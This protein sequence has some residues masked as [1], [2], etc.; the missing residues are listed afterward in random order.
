MLK[1]KEEI[2]I[3]N[4]FLIELL[5]LLDQQKSKTQINA[6]IKEME[7]SIR[8]LKLVGI[9]AKGDTK[10]EVNQTIRQMEGNLRQIKIQAK[11]DSRQLNRE[12]NSALRNVSARDIQLNVSSSERLGIQV[13]RAV[14][15]AREFVSRNPISVNIDLKKE[16]LLNQLT[17]FTNKHTKINESSY[18]LGE[19]ER[20]RNVIGSITNRDELRNAT[21]Q[22]QVFT[23]GVRATGYAAVSTTDRI[24]GMLGNVV[25]IS[26][27]FG[28]AFMAVNKFR[29]SINT[30]KTND[31]ILVEISKTSEMTKQQLRELGDEAFAVASKF[32]Q[33]S[34]NYLLAVQ[35]MA[36]SGYE[37]MSKELGQLS[38]L[39]Q[40]AG[41]MT[42]EM[43]NNYLLAT[44]AAYKYGGSVDK[45]TAALDGA[46]YISNKNSASLTDIADGIRVSASFAANAGV[47]IDEL[48]AAEA[49]MVAATKRSG[50]EMGR[51]FRS[52]ILNLQ[53]ISGEF[54]GEVI[55]E[56]QLK[57]VEDRC[58]SLGVELEYIKDGVATLRNPMEILKDLAEVYNSLPDNSAEK[59]GL[60]SDIGGKY[61]ANALSALLSRWDLYEKMVGEFSQ[62]TGSALEE[63]NKTADSWEGRLNSLSNSF[64]SFVA[65]ITNKDVIKGG[66][67]FLDN[68]IQS[69]EKLSDTI[70]AIPVILTTF[71]AGMTALNKNYGITQLY[72]K[73][74]HKMDIQGNIMGIDITAFKT[75]QK[76]FREAANAILTWNNQLL[77][78]TADIDAFG[79][80]VVQNNE[81]LKA[82][83]QTTSV[84]APASLA[85]YRSYLA[86]C[87]VS[88]DALR[89]KTVLLNSAL[90][91]GLSL[92]IQAVATAVSSFIRVSG[93]VAQKADEV[94]N[95]FTSAKTDIEGYKSKVEEL[96][97]VLNDSGSSISDVTEARKSLMSIQDELIEKY[98]AEKGA[99][100]LITEGINGQADAFDK[101]AE[102]QWQEAKN[103]FNGGG[104]ANDAAN[105]INGYSDNIDRMLDEYGNYKVKLDLSVATTGLSPEEAEGL[106]GLF[107]SNG[108]EVT[109]GMKGTYSNN[110]FVELSGNAT[111]MHEK[112]LELQE[113][114][115]DENPL[116]TDNFRNY[117]TGLANSAKEVS[118][119]YKDMYDNYTLYKGIAGNEGY[120]S[121]FGNIKD[122]YQKYQGAKVS[123]N[124]QEIAE[125]AESYAKIVSD[126]S[127]KALENGNGGVAGYFKSMYPE[128][129]SIVGQWEFK[130]KIIPDF[131]ISG[132]QGK[133]EGG[134]LKMLQTEGLQEGESV[135]NSIIDKAKEY[136][137]I[138]SDNADGIQEVL[139]L[140]TEWK[141][142][143][144]DI[145]ETE[146]PE[147]PSYKDSLDGVQNVAGNLHTLMEVYDD[148]Q[149]GKEFDWSSILNN[150]D[151]E[152]VFSSAG[153]VYDD[154]IETVT[155]NPD[156]ITACQ[157]AFDKLATSLIDS[158]GI[159]DN[160]TAETEKATVAMLEENGVV[161]AAEL[162][163]SRLAIQEEWLALTKNNASLAG[164]ELSDVTWEEIGALLSEGDASDTT[165]GYL[166]ALAISKMDVNSI[167]IDT[168]DDVNQ[169]I[170]IANAAGTSTSY[171]QALANALLN[172]K[173]MQF[174]TS[175]LGGKAADAARDVAVNAFE[176]GLKSTLSSQLEGAKLDAS[177]FY[178]KSGG[179]GGSGKSG[180]S[181]KPGSGKSG[182]KKQE[183]KESIEV[184][185][186]IETAISRVEEAIDR[187]KTK[188]GETFRSFTRRGREYRKA[189][190]EITKEI[191]I[192]RKGYDKYIARAN[193]IGLE[194]AWAAQVRDGSINIADVADDGLKERIKN[195]KEW[196]E[197]ALQCQEKLEE[198]EKTQKELAREKIELLI[199]KYE[200]LLSKLE[201]ASKR[202]QGAMDLKETW[203][204]SAS[205]KDYSK[206]NRNA[207]SQISNIIKQNKKLKELQK[208]VTKGSEAW[209]EYNGRINSNNESIQGLAKTMAENAIASASLAGQDAEAKNSAKDTADEKTDTKLST[210]STA[211]RKNSLTS[212]KAKN[213]DARQKNLQAA[214]A[215]TSKSRA[216]YGDKILKSSKKGVSKKN[217]KLFA[218]AIAKV[219]AGKL[220]PTSVTNGIVSAMKTA[221]GKE[222][223]E[224]DTLLSY[225]NYYNAN[226]NAEEE[227]RL[228]LE[229]YALT[230]QEEKKSLRQEQLSNSLEANQSKAE[231][232]TVSNAET[233]SAK[234]HNINTQ[235]R[236]SK[237]DRDAQT[238]ARKTASKDRKTAAG[239]AKFYTGKAY[240]KLRNKKLKNRLK[241]AASAIKS[242]KKISNGALE[243]VKEYCEKYL[244]GDLTYYYSCE[245]YNE[246][247]ENELS[248]KESETLAKAQ[249]YAG[250]LQA[251]QEKAANTVSGR[252][253]EN[254][255]H[256]ATSK[257]QTTAGAKNRYVDSQIS[258]ITKNASTYKSAYNTAKKDFSNAKK[259]IEGNKSKNKTVKEIKS[260]YVNKNILI[261]AS[262]IEK[263]YAVSNSFGLACSNYNEALSAMEAA[264]ETSALYEQTARTEKAALALEKMSNIDTEYSHKESEYT[265]RA[266][267]INNAMD[268]IQAKGYQTSKKYY[269]GLLQNE[270]GTSKVLNSKLAELTKSLEESVGNGIVTKFSDEWY[271][272]QGRINDVANAIDEA[273]VSM[274]EFKS[275]IRQIEWDNFD[276]LQNRVKDVA[277]ELSF[278]VNEMSREGVADD[279]IGWLTKEGKS[280]AWLHANS[281]ELY[282]KHAGEYKKAVEGINKELAD[283]PYN[284]TLL[285]RRQELVK[286]YQ[287]AVEG[288][289]DE[290]YAVIDLYEQG[291]NALS[292]KL[293]TLISEYGE[294]LDTQKDAFEYSDTIADKTKEIAALRKQV[295]AYAGD[296]SEETRAK[297]Q[298]IKVSLEEA[299][300]NL[301]ETQ[302]GRYISDTKNMLSDL[303]GDFDEAIQSIIDSLS[304]NFGE[305]LSGISQTA[306]DSVQEITSH[307][308]GIG[309]TPTDEFR[310]LLDGSSITSSVSAMLTGLNDYHAKMEAYA[311]RIATG[312][313]ILGDITGNTGT[314][315]TQGGNGTA[316][317]NSGTGTATG[318]TA[319]GNA[320]GTTN[321]KG[322]K[323]GLTAVDAGAL[324]PVAT[325]T[326]I[327]G[328]KQSA[329]KKNTA[330]K[331][332]ALSYLDKNL[333][334]TKAKRDTLSD[335]NKKFYDKFNKKIL[336][337]SQMKGL[338]KLLGVK[339]DSQKS[340]GNLY[341]K[342]KEIGIK[343]F[344]VGSHSIPYDQLAFLGE[345]KDELHFKKNEG[346]LTKVGQGDMVF[347]NEMAQ[348]LW[349]ISQENPELI[350]EKFGIPAPIAQGNIANPPMV[351][352]SQCMKAG[353]VTMNV[354]FGDMNLPN[355][356]DASNAA[357]VKG[358]MEDAICE[359]MC[360][361][362]RGRKCVV[363]SVAS[364]LLGRGVGHARLYATN[365]RR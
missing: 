107:E 15:E 328:D 347:T 186:F 337:T 28:L 176:N 206:L 224:L 94:S 61:H 336:T 198:L 295:E 260:K 261:P 236:Q 345:G 210:A 96:Q 296:M 215:K 47:A 327:T 64:D 26:N 143:Q 155:K 308:S 364:G 359:I 277:S 320:G 131:D 249:Y 18:W 279:K 211:S 269:E 338:A 266:T 68:A 42:A 363:E 248:A 301:Q 44:D 309:Y 20:L 189:I 181:G 341:K 162:V 262:Y 284:R 304:E 315:A 174:D 164:R 352:A 187:L 55:D 22:L 125:A 355:V 80:A 3:L 144:K 243:A 4:E 79:S 168:T 246:A 258:N 82:Y 216:S 112:L 314:N 281:Y 219:K 150:D 323:Q 193:S 237:A 286:S 220:I 273:A 324:K 104:L 87:G 141:I 313:G 49:A 195:Y 30:L 184:F 200:K 268:I 76:H 54:D 140:L 290:K 182:S 156:N 13:R 101:L 209:H 356:T 31:T 159:W 84:E 160:L 300:K 348:R 194:G 306:G 5:A 89:L 346:T 25:K 272:A 207:Q 340:S 208:T 122:A 191:D 39:A 98:G 264:K 14:S 171:I 163:A 113:M 9:L 325:L 270:E 299:E 242:G 120:A 48:T 291:Y 124:A 329:A 223:K 282:R 105:F 95:T 161:N 213:I 312:M 130:T 321:L 196:Y 350:R 244:K 342:L 233:T 188:A 45:L 310:S 62:G 126:A 217:R 179:T 91:L 8:K 204:F 88:T 351:D 250:S 239:K 297:V 133:T 280:T 302:Y 185:D 139:G 40:S 36:R 152:E 285:D 21:D 100:D 17:A 265:Q 316:G 102:K 12:I 349:E 234:N 83:L 93:D 275:Q 43:A 255:L 1:I 34:G 99:I 121:A 344:R 118:G 114:F 251:K 201:S 241:K 86:S 166:A 38:L 245:A 192:Q 51:S 333:K 81:Q 135:F 74:T 32:G 221:R 24:K 222:Y 57:K 335:T 157:D 289:Q 147:P 225:C 358:M 119:Q 226:K 46:N 75:Q 59:Q 2:G 27:A 23:T 180:K 154:F 67:S 303:Q 230:A 37:I 117:L 109:Y 132:L 205:T 69:F 165:S 263:A 142:L 56:E 170:A 271:E 63:A 137:I 334:T 212:S 90:T 362:S 173:S 127:A 202:I 7:K 11:M 16:K 183:E 53:Q 85:G 319:S 318:T 60:I 287:D 108:M 360:T 19:A 365:H 214:Y 276:Y 167:T 77:A 238:K 197:K 116:S 177:K 240:K 332:D 58:H 106:K 110:P 97:A 172:F 145:S 10:N 231:R 50:S 153:K 78:G 274:A 294:L 148:V 71:Q 322:G 267:R 70:G 354:T 247:V 229:M 339:Y 35:E 278:M 115:S 254:G 203:G 190:S 293:K 257:N 227:N 66:V 103:E 199:T 307:M 330:L 288:A 331:T 232:S 52:I 138:T 6:Q 252:E 283:D 256:A 357:E 169:I 111:E 136:G 146:A 259:K 73:D 253:T 33:V 123:G 218:Q 292:N 235:T 228:N 128:L 149:D 343:G 72:N 92:G 158:S 305:L 311:D 41:D 65:S 175:T 151:F 29:Q 298:G 361:N 134:I 129:Q 326:E 178:A 353:D 317:N